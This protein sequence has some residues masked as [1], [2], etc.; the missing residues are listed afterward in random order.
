MRTLSNYIVMHMQKA[1]VYVALCRPVQSCPCDLEIRPRNR[2]NYEWSRKP[3]II[4]D[5]GSVNERIRYPVM[6]SPFAEPIPRMVLERRKYDLINYVIPLWTDVKT[7]IKLNATN[8]G[9]L[10]IC[11]QYA[12]CRYPL[13][14]MNS[15]ILNKNLHHGLTLLKL[16]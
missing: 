15:S 8:L 12:I 5:T 13:V 2:G 1:R 14:N 3:G 7:T 16:S 11:F 6:L 9:I 10:Y 4:Q